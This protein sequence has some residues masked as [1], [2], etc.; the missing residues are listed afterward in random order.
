MRG[1]IINDPVYG[2]I[3]FPEQEMMQVIEHKWFQR[4]RRIKQMGMAHLVYPGAVHTRLHH[5]LGAAH[6]MNIA[7]SELRSKGIDISR[8]ECIAARLAILM[9]DIGHGPFSHGLEHTIVHDI[10]HETISRLIMQRLNEEMDGM[11][12]Y[13]IA[14][15]DN[16]HPK[17]FLHQLVSSQLD[18][19]RMDY[20][21]RD[22]FYTGVSEGVI[23][24][25]RILQMLTVKDGGLV[26]EEKGIHSVEKFIVAR[27]L[28]YWQV[29]LHKTVLGAE[30]LIINVLKRARDLAQKGVDL[31]ATPSFRFFLYE[32]IN[33]HDFLSEPAIL[34]K[35][36]LLDDADI[37]ASIKV[38]TSHPDKILSQ[39]CS[40]LENRRLYKVRLSTQPLEHEFEKMKQVVLNAG[41]I[42]EEDLEY[43]L[44]K[45]T[46]SNNTYNQYD[47]KINILM[48]NG[49]ILN[50]SDVDNALISSDLTVPV[51]K[52]YICRMP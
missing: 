8:D 43:F 32:K 48:K 29:Y 11:L 25:D 45:G 22:S 27:R 15:F 5:S 52:F 20:L 42:N 37:A 39:L 36:C 6:L 31:F 38:W 1:K 47:E 9:H 7:L 28:M 51:E 3:R 17:T 19:D 2:F 23:G 41:Q 50:I 13:A 35:F 44:F 24:Y 12:T 4:L 33:G 40:M 46:T 10:S 49:D 14:I 16:T 26:V 18:M 21:N 30:H 34:E